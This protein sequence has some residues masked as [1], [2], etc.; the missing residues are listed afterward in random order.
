MHTHMCKQPYVDLPF[1]KQDLFTPG[2][3]VPYNIGM[4][5]NNFWIIGSHRYPEAFAISMGVSID[6]E[7][8]FSV[9]YAPEKQW[10][11]KPDNIAQ[12]CQN[13]NAN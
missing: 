1:P 9:I 3:A 11:R 6:R 8:I 12:P 10:N 7:I 2:A 5:Q 13:T 4:Y